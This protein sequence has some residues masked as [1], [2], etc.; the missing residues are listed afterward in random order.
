M[1]RLF[2]ATLALGFVL[3]GCA[4]G[5]EGST[6]RRDGSADGLDAGEPVRRDAGPPGA[7]AGVPPGTDAGPPP[8]VDAGPPAVCAP[9]E[10][11]TCMLACGASGT[12]SCAGGRFG[13]CVAGAEVCNGMDDD[14]NGAVDDGFACRA[15]TMEACMTTCGST[16]MRTCTAACTAGV[17]VPPAEACNGRDDDCAGGVDDGALCGA[18]EACRGGACVRTSWV[19]EAEG[20]AMG[21][22][23]GRADAD[24]WSA[25]TAADARGYL[26]FGPYASEIP[27]GTYT[28]SFRMMVDNNTADDGVVVRIEV[29]DFDGTAGTC[30]SCVIATRDVRRMEFTGAMAYQDFALAFTNPGGHRLEFRTYWQDISYVRE[31]RIEVR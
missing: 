7:D 10:M 13:P 26:A 22:A 5:D 23:I 27:A 18:D 19:Y 11:R 31:D 14:C 3:G 16:G 9:G 1:R 2:V 8:P 20:A 12:S 30:G 6:R 21:H 15:G 4:S 24:G 28:A 17:C 29:N 25:N